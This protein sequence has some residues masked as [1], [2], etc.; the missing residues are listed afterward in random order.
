[1]NSN[2][3]IENILEL[4][5][6]NR[7]FYENYVSY[8]SIQW[9]LKLVDNLSGEKTENVK[10]KLKKIEKEL[11]GQSP[12]AMVWWYSILISLDANS[13]TFIDFCRYIKSKQNYFSMNTNYFL[14][15]Q[16][17]YIM[18]T[19]EMLISNE[20]I[21][22][23]NKYFD[24]IVDMFAERLSVSLE[25]IPES[26][27]NNNTSI[28]VISQLLDFNNHIEKRVIEKCKIMNDVMKQK[29]LLINTT[30]VLNTVGKVPFY[31]AHYSKCDIQKK[32]EE[33][34]EFEGRKI[35][36][37]QC[38]YPMPSIE[39]IEIILK[40]IRKMAPRCVVSFTEDSI[41]SAL[42]N[43]IIPVVYEKVG[44]SDIVCSDKSEDAISKISQLGGQ[45]ECYEIVI[46]VNK[47]M[48]DFHKNYLD[49]NGDRYCEF[50]E[51]S[52]DF[53]PLSYGCYCIYDK[54]VQQF[55]GV[56]S[57]SAIEN[58]EQVPILEEDC[59]SDITLEFDGNWMQYLE[60]LRE[61]SERKIYVICSNIKRI[62]SYYK[63]PELKKYM[64]N[65]K[66]FSDRTEY[67]QYFHEHLNKYLPRII[68]AK[69]KR[70]E[71]Q[72]KKIIRNEH[73]YRMTDEGRDASNVLLTIGIP[74]HNRGNLLLMRLEKLLKMQYDSEIEVVVTKN[75]SALYQDEY[76]EASNIKD[77]RYIYYGV[78]ENLKAYHNWYNVTKFAH[79]KYIM[80]VSDE[81]DVIISSLAY[82]LKLLKFNPNLSIV[83]AG[84]HKQY[85]GL[86]SV[87]GKKGLD[88]FYKVFLVQ[89]YLSGL[90]INKTKFCEADVMKYEVYSDNAFYKNYPHEWWCAELSLLGDYSS[91]NRELI[92]ENECVLNEECDKY[93]KLGILKKNTLV[94][95]NCGLPKYATYES[96][97]EQ[98]NGMIEFIKIFMKENKR[99]VI[100]GIEK[101]INK[102]AFLLTIARAY[103]YKKEEYQNIIEKYVVI[104]SESINLVISDEKQKNVIINLIRANYNT[105]K[106]NKI[107]NDELDKIK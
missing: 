32:E 27:R 53:Y 24:D 14:Y 101:A 67:Q 19:N 36:Y 23:V 94:D 15:C 78:D 45:G 38:E 26:M 1:M 68:F 80:F 55:R 81:D 56:L 82:Y 49:L 84:T 72:L 69:D 37:F 31:N 11:D 42:V 59:F 43:K 107:Q 87:Y 20:N 51:C 4:I 60:I 9:G 46:D 58:T 10:K 100:L 3:I 7:D 85:E 16:L 13:K 54:E 75:G 90:I 50:N 83:R 17:K 66:I 47:V 76:I 74:T 21:N 39:Q 22:E 102:L 62:I 91:E 18:E 64:K 96:R 8:E 33:F 92:Y 98:F 104:T 2:E 28:V 70:D 40:Q 12:Y 30:E 5:H 65:I 99:G 97:F 86:R 73:R 89:N 61:A 79:G 35:P 44:V 52:L 41:F 25:E 77:S 57:V 71:Y 88:A 63:I 106:K 103:G 29:V 105:L 6:E 34:Q 48:N 93:E 95:E